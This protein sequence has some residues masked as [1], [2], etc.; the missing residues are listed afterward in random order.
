[1]LQFPQVLVEVGVEKAQEC[2]GMLLDS[3]LS[4]K[5]WTARK[6]VFRSGSGVIDLAHYQMT[7]YL[8][9]KKKKIITERAPREVAS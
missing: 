6:F 3:G 8:V 7:Q 5:A 9:L 1:M 2:E 4:L